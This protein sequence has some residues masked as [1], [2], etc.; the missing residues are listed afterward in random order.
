MKNHILLSPLLAYRSRPYFPSKRVSGES[1]K[2]L[3][4]VIGESIDFLFEPLKNA[5]P[6][7]FGER[8]RYEDMERLRVLSRVELLLLSTVF[9][10]ARLMTDEEEKDEED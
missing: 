10:L 6:P 4:S 7:R 1:A 8:G 5:F 3:T 9:F 2:G